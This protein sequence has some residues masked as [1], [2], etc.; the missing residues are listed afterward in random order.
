MTQIGYLERIRKQSLLT[1]I[2]LGLLVI[3]AASLAAAVDLNGLKI[4][5]PDLYT[6]ERQALIEAEWQ[7]SQAF[8]HEPAQLDAAPLIHQQVKAALDWLDRASGADPTHHQRIA[9][10]QRQIMALEIADQQ[11]R[12]SNAQRVQI[13]GRLLDELKTLATEYQNSTVDRGT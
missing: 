1:F 12:A 2:A 6:P 9:E 4:D 3:L 8:A 10:L 7:L 13:Y 11:A 5:R